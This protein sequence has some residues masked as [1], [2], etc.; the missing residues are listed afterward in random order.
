MSDDG[1]CFYII[2]ANGQTWLEFGKQGTVDVFSTNSVNV[3]TQGTINL[4][5][6]RDINM[7]AGRNIKMHANANVIMEA[8]VDCSVIVQKNLTIWSQDTVGVKA[9]GAISVQSASGSWN[10]GAS[11]LFTAGGIDLN[12][13][14]APAVTAPTPITKV[15]LDDTDFSTSRGWEAKIDGLETICSRATSHEPFQYH[16]KGVDV[17]IEFEPGDPDPPPAAPP[18]PAGVELVAR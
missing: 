17:K 8:D 15:L 7:F 9:D 5:A 1:D 11:L 2:H 10:G 13:P 18:V 6:D 3:R 12:G 4:H 16:N 14:A